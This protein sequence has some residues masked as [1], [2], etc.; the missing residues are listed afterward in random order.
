MA[1]AFGCMPLP[2]FGFHLSEAW[3]ENVA[4]SAAGDSGWVTCE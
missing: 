3:R 4:E 1:V 2:I